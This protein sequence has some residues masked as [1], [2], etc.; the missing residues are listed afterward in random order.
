MLLKLGEVLESID[1]KNAADPSHVLFDG[2]DYATALIEGVRA[3]HWVQH[4]RPDAPAPLLIAAR[5]HHFRRW[6]IPRS[7]YPRSRQGYLAWRNRL[8]DFQAEAVAEVME[9]AGYTHDAIAQAGRLLRK[10]DLK[11][12]ADT[13]TYEDA[14][15]LAFLEVRL[16]SFMDTVTAEQLTRALHSTWRKMSESGHAAALTL[17]L[18]PR[19]AKVISRAL[20]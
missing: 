20:T 15:S 11:A 5:G 17:T 12:D 10:Q 2:T 7:S 18:E 9:Q 8:Y 1:R 19:V 14:V 4:L 3:H 13:Q 16:A 6:E